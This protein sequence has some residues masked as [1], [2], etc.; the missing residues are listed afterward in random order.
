MD[1]SKS[2]F[3]GREHRDRSL[4]MPGDLGELARDA[5]PAP[6]ADVTANPGSDITFSY[7]LD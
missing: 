4:D 2:S 1:A 5:G 6:L 3:G 7:E